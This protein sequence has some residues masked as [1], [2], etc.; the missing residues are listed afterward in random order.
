MSYTIKDEVD[1]FVANQVKELRLKNKM[2]QTKL[3]LEL[4]VSHS[5][6]NQIE[7]PTQRARYNIQ[8]LNKLALIFKCSP[9]DFLPELPIL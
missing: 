8:H 3:G 6:I 1:I 7:L 5:F 2:S 9:R 4:G